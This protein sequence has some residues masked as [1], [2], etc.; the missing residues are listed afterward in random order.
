M[1]GSL[2]SASHDAYADSDAVDVSEIGAAWRE[3]CNGTWVTSGLSIQLFVEMPS[4]EAASCDRIFGG[5]QVI[6]A[7]NTGYYVKPAAYAGAHPV[8]NHDAHF[9]SR[10]DSATCLFPG[11]HRCERGGC[12]AFSRYA[13]ADGLQNLTFERE[14]GAFDPELTGQLMHSENLVVRCPVGYRVQA[15][16]PA[17]ASSPRFAKAV[18]GSDCSITRVQCQRITCGNFT[19]PANS[20]ASRDNSVPGISGGTEVDTLLYGE[21]VTVSC[22]ENHRLGAAGMNCSQ[23]G[24]RVRCGDEGQLEYEDGMASS[25]PPAAQTCVPIECIVSTVDDSNGVLKTPFFGEG[26]TVSWGHSL[27]SVAHGHAVTVTCNAGYRVKPQGF[28]GDYALCHHKLNFSITCDI[29]SLRLSIACIHL[30]RRV[31]VHVCNQSFVYVRVSLLSLFLSFSL[32]LSLSLS[33]FM[34]VYT[35]CTL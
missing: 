31:C 15:T 22:V 13:T 17:Q 2:G 20:M 26:N 5:S 19:V 3:W 18:C 28:S 10:C 32:Y 23:R 8:C 6:V 4:C 14:A 16:S 7:C 33:L 27:T 25:L 34:R 29:R 21:T 24:F 35:N 11:K 30:L 1:N 12:F 9:T